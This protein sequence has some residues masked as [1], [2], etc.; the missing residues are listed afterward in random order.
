MQNALTAES[1]PR[2]S[3]PFFTAVEL[4]QTALLEHARLQFPHGRRCESAFANQRKAERPFGFV[5]CQSDGRV[6]DHL[7][8][9]AFRHLAILGGDASGDLL[10]LAACRQVVF[11]H[12]EVF[13]E[14]HR[15]VDDRGEDD[16]ERPILFAGHNLP[17]Q[18]LDDLGGL[19]EAME[20]FQDEQGRR[21]LAGQG[22]DRTDGGQRIISGGIG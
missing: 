14:F 22:I 12:H 7:Q 11:E 9:A 18:R 15:D 19:H 10:D 4:Q 2:L 3:K 20:V 21:V 6:E 5:S 8:V 1:P 13:L 16:D 17:G